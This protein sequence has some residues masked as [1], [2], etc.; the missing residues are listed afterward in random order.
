MLAR[1]VFA[2]QTSDLNRPRGTVPGRSNGKRHRAVARAALPCQDGSLK[3][4]DGR[5]PATVVWR[6]VYPESP[7]PSRTW[8]LGSRR[9][10]H[11]AAGARPLLL[12]GS[13]ASRDDEV[14]R[15][16]RWCAVA[17]YLVRERA[18]AT[19]AGIE[20]ERKPCGIA[21]HGPPAVARISRDRDGRISAKRPED[22]PSRVAASHD[23]PLVG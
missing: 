14:R 19:A 20:S 17:G 9:D 4:A 3:L 22:K 21:R 1:R 11:I 5:G 15:T 18:A 8:E 16:W 6:R 2:T 23:S 10:R 7:R 12:D 13:A